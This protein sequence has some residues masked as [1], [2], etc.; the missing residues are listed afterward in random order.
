MTLNVTVCNMANYCNKFCSLNSQGIFLNLEIWHHCSI[1][2]RVYCVD[3]PNMLW[4]WAEGHNSLNYCIVIFL[5]GEI[6]EKDKADSITWPVMTS[7]IS[8]DAPLFNRKFVTIHTCHTEHEPLRI[9]YTNIVRKY[10]MY[11]INEVFN[12]TGTCYYATT[13]FSV[14]KCREVL[15]FKSV[16]TVKH[17]QEVVFLHFLTK[18]GK[19]HKIWH[20]KDTIQFS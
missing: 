12:H 8:H 9:V 20:L 16:P 19:A 5:S 1:R 2:L 15:K 6:K 14:T 7:P 11:S 18:L 17:E 13:N 4:G 10:F 3:C